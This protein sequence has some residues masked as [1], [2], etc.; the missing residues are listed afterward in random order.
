M[1]IS[2]K[3]YVVVANSVVP[4]RVRITV[5]VWTDETTFVTV[6]M[7]PLEVGVAE[8]STDDDV[9]VTADEVSTGLEV[10]VEDGSVNV[11]ATVVSLSVETC[12][13]LLPVEALVDDVEEL[14]GV[15]DSSVVEVEVVPGL[16]EE[17]E[18][19]GLLEPNHG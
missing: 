1:M 13:E 12:V 6:T 3:S 19:L 10:L 18:G 14:A 8:I 16:L 11:A 15:V 5:S 4:S 2:K 7:S 17:A 9:D